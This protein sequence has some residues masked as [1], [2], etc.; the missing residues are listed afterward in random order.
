MRVRYTG[1]NPTAFVALGREV[2]PGEE[3]PIPDDAA[4]GYL[5]RQ[6]IKPV[7]PKKPPAA[8]RAAI[9]SAP[10]GPEDVTPAPQAPD[11]TTT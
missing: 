10:S 8:K 2:Q 1:A 11:E 9:P 5:A 7:A 6:D 4:D 3:F